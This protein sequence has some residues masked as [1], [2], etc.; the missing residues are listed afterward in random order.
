MM[1]KIIFIISIITFAD[2]IIP[3]FNVIQSIDFDSEQ[4][5]VYGLTGEY[6]YS[7]ALRY[8]DGNLETWNLTQIFNIGFHWIST[9]IDEN[10]N[11]YVFMD[12]IYKFDG[13]SWS[14][15]DLPPQVGDNKC[16]DLNI[17]N[18]YLWLTVLAYEGAHRLNLTDLTWTSYDSLTAEYSSSGIISITGDSVWIP[19]SKGL[20]LIYNEIVSVILDT[21]ISSIPTQK[22]YCFFIDSN[23]NRWLGSADGGLIRWVNDTTFISYNT[24][25]SSLPHNF[26]NAIE[27]DSK[28]YLWIATDGGFACL[29]NDTINS[30]SYLL[31]KPIITLNVDHLDRIWFGDLGVGNLLMFDGSNLI[32]ITSVSEESKLYTDF[33]LSQNYPNPFNPSTNIE[34]RTVE[35]GFVNLKVYDVLGNEIA[36][37]INEE[38]PAG[39]YEVTFDAFALSSG[40]YFYKL[41]AGKYVEAKKMV[42]LK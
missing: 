39:K 22:L 35:F 8:K 10:D 11:I 30:Y 2:N 29:K 15:I 5:V 14:Q 26:V 36:V 40:V 38:K 4:R 21:L 1:K 32:T 9:T 13:F 24:G 23:E 31:S 19:T 17:N 41:Q 34:F 18:N 42:L 25:N 7:Y 6:D 12:K 37:L 28:G 3:Q 16:S 33:I 20:V 27:E